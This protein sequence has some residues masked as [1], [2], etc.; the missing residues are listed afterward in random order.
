MIEKRKDNI[1]NVIGGSGSLNESLNENLDKSLN[2][3]LNELLN[4]KCQEEV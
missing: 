2:G 4:M 1:L 3:S